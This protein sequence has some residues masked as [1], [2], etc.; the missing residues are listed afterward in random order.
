M[1]SSTRAAA[2]GEGATSGVTT[3][4][5]R[6]QS[7]AKAEA[8]VTSATA[9]PPGSGA[10]QPMR[11]Q[12][13]P[14]STSAGLPSA[15]A[16]R[17][18]PSARSHCSA[19]KPDALP[20]VPSRP[21]GPR[22]ASASPVGATITSSRGPLAAPR[23]PSARTGTAVSRRSAVRQI[24]VDSSARARQGSAQGAKAGRCRVDIGAEPRIRA[25]HS[26]ARMPQPTQCHTG[27]SRP[28]G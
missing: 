18:S 14:G 21:S 28:S 5:A 23:S 11:S 1:R 4:A 27:A 16:S 9:P 3:I 22:I 6:R 24:T 20:S 2:Q 12:R 8:S 15:S 17:G 7:S 19:V 13:A 10:V 25:T 26:T